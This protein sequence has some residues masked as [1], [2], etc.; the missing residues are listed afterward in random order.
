[1][2]ARFAEGT[3]VPI[4][5]SEMEIKLLLRKHGATEVWSGANAERAAIGFKMRDRLIRMDLPLPR[6]D[7]KR[8][9]HVPGR[10]W[11]RR[12]A[13][14]QRSAYDA[15]LRRRWRALLL[16]VKAKLEVV[17]SEIVSFESEWM[18]HIV[19]ADGRTV[20]ELAL[21]A[22]SA[23]YENGKMPQTFLGLPAPDAPESGAID[24]EFDGGPNG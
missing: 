18:A 1:M 20:G 4:E 11:L 12:T 10:S 8:F 19:A 13:E 6:S 23:M 24:A 16:A 21:P 14:Q 2:S 7:D 9:T 15:E 3:T 17:A 22:I 5:K